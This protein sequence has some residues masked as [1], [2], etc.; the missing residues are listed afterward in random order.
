[1]KEPDDQDTGEKSDKSKSD[2]KQSLKSSK[3]ESRSLMKED[4]TDETLTEG[5]ESY[6]EEEKTDLEHVEGSSSSFQDDDLETTRV[7]QE[8]P[9]VEE[10]GEEVKKKISESF[11][12]DYM[13]LV[14]IPFVTPDSNIPLD[15]L[16]LVHSF[17]YDCRKR[18]NLQLLDNNTALY[19]AGNQLILLNLKTKEQ[20]YLQSS[21]GEGIGVIG[22]HPHKTHFAVAEKGSFPKII[23]YEYPSLRPYRI[24]RDGTEQAYAYVDF[25]NNG[26]LLASVGSNPD[27][28]LTIWNWKE[29]QPILRTKAFPQEVYKVTFNPENEE[30]LTTSGS[31]HIKFWEMAF[32]FTGLKLQGAL[33][34]FGKTTTTDIEGYMELPDGKVLS[35]STW[36]NMLLWEAGLIKVELCRNGR[37]SCHHGAINQ[38]M[39]DEG[40]V[41]TVGSDGCVRIWDFETID[42][43]DVINDTG[44]LEIEPMNELQV[45]KNVKLSS[46][47]KMNEIGSN[48]WL[49]QDASG[50]IWKLDLSF[51]NITQDPECLFS[52]HSGA[53][54]ALAVSPVTYLMATTALDCSVRIYDFAGKTP[55]AQ[56][57]F[58]QG[59]TALTWAPQ[60]VSYTGAQICVGFED[61]VVRIL[62]IYDPKGLTVFAGRKKILGADLQLKYVFKPHTAAVTA[63]AYER[64][65]EILATGSKDN[66]VFFF[67]IEKDY[68]PIGYI[69]TP[70]PVCQLLW[71]TIAHPDSTLLIICENG[72]VLEA[73]PP[74]RKEEDDQHVVSYKI[75]HM[76]IKCFHFSSVKS[77]ILRLIEIEKREE[78]KRLKEKEREERRKQLAEEMGEEEEEFQEEE[79]VEE[80]EEE[81]L[82]AIFIPP[83]PSPIL[84]GFYSEPGKFWVSLGGYD[85]GFLYHCEFPPY[86]MN[87]DFKAQK[88]EPFDFRFLEDTEDNPVQVITFSISQTMMFCGMRNGAIR[89]YVLS[90]DDLSLPSLMDYWH[91]NVHDNNYGCIKSIATSFDD[92]FLMTAGAD[93]NI[94]VFNIF[95]EYMLWQEIK[96]TVPSPRY[97]FEMEP[98]PADIEDPKAYSIESARRKREHDKLMKEMEEIKA[99]KREQLKVLRNEFSKLL[100]MNEELPKHMQFK[101]T[102]FDLDNKIRAEINRKTAYKLHQVEL[103]LAWEKEKHGLG[104]R[105]LENRFRDPLESDSI[106]VHAIQSDHKIFSYR[107][108]QPSKYSRLKR[109]SQTER[110]PSKLERF[111]KEGPGRKDSQKD[112]G[113]SVSI[114]EDSII[115]KGKKFRPKTLS[116]IMVD[117]QIVKTR[118]LM[119]KAERAQLKIQQRK[120]EWEELY[121]SKPADDYEDPKDLI[122]IKEAQLYMGDFNLKTAPDYKIPEHM[123]IN[124][125]KKEEELGHLDSLVHG[126]KRHMNKCILSLRDLKVAIIEEIH[127]LVQE[128]KTI[129]STLPI[130]KH[131][132]I[133]Q[134]PQIQPDEVPEKRF[135]YDEEILLN[136]KE[137][138]IKSKDEKFPQVEQTGLGGAFLKLPP[139][140]DGDVATR[141]SIPRSS[142]GSGLSPDL[143]KLLEF[144]KVEPTDVELEIMKRDEIKHLYMQQYLVNRIKE[145]IITFDAE[146]R[147]LRHQKLKLDIQMKLSDLH[148]ITLFQEMLLLKNFEKQENILQER[149]NSLDKEEQFMQWKINETFKEMEEK[150]SEISKLQDQEKALYAGFQTAIG[151]NNKFA[152]FLM[153][154]LKKKIKRVKKKDVEGDA[155]EDEESEES[156][157][158]ESSLESDE[159]ES[160]SENEVFDDSICPTNCDVGLFEMALQLR[161]KRLDIEEALVEEK[162]IVE[163]LKKEYDTLS[164]KVK[165]VAANLNAAEEDLEA[166]QR[167]K[168][169]R[170]NELLVAIPLKLHQIEYMVFG[171]IPADLSGTLVF[172]NHSL[173]RLQE[174]IIQLQEENVKQQKLNK[175]CRERRKQLVR[176]KK[177]MAKTIHKMEE[178]VTQ[179]MISKFGRVI[180]LE[181]LQTLSVNVTLEEL[182]IKKLR[183]E[184]L[185]AKEMKMWEEKIAHVRWELMRKTKEHTKKLHQMNDLCIE[186]K[187]LDSRLNTLQNQQGNA[188]QGPRKAD[189]VA[190]EKVTELIQAQAQRI[191]ALKE[192][193]TVLR[194]KGGLI[195]PPIQSSQVNEIKPTNL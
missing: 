60:L 190:M 46:M 96:A 47:I 192:E 165:V 104:L 123:R 41:I 194:K 67:N 63:L 40:E 76:G 148:H 9:A 161:E 61:G 39:L 84:C 59:G 113:G 175:E 114:Q 117:N 38:I 120:K 93:S 50:A 158:E 24:L 176:E 94:F 162:K 8:T 82:P 95:S 28:T 142:K 133:P 89:I 5:E 45:G 139:G 19:V 115:E 177:E 149:V 88:D 29:E 185:N 125:A 68:K 44:L 78:K 152:N 168:Q 25:N 1:M 90:E 173:D 182:K 193:I 138:Q 151:E 126:K 26:N 124:A 144:E 180:D 166:Y 107:L 145:L 20:N 69:N 155:D 32:T 98:I 110:R 191:S 103:E 92:R 181:A 34:R 127:C 99:G 132:P 49:A 128:L 156:S 3:S 112:T 131:I 186:K 22:V 42:T 62:E 55:L 163:N 160:G 51:S 70:G 31:G 147:V 30:Q 171:E 58:K 174:R 77:K 56:M 80:E 172:S 37:K 170:L 105:K 130:F 135:H 100:A 65:G 184:L 73:P 167:E 64:D 178:T 164:K 57:K 79:A 11:Y 97:G 12:Y 122:A 48:F 101:R 195:L 43:A 102:D 134:I 159:D 7:S 85:S 137:Q 15:L 154:V 86:D 106:V 36:G 14:S 153:K 111:D 140:K 6:L 150:K 27:Y 23:I 71:S 4:T 17:G 187:K 136:F 109:A 141:E 183:K 179:L 146:L 189:I 21:S 52:F 143:S 10:E 188:F 108:V 35:G 72:Y 118:K 75:K 121:K 87:S 13:E 81:P 2:G 119:L 66:T 83:T 53:I 169:Q 16:S 157:E 91:F 129:Q 74:T 33:G 18:A 116:E 54:E